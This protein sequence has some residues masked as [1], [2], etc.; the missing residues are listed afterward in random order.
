MVTQ[1]NHK[2]GIITSKGG[3]L[4]QIHQLKPIFSKH[5]RFWVTFKGKDEEYLLKNEKKYF[6]FYPES[7][8]LINA[9]LN[10]FL[11]WKILTKEKPNILISAGAGIAPPFFIVGKIMGMKLIFI[12]PYDFIHHPSL[13]GKIVS[14]FV[15]LF[16]VQH[17]EQLSFYKKAKYWGSL[18]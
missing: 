1:K 15:D 5:N 10:F 17:K 7:R 8:N 2:I 16:L 18:L 4:F 11:A 3:H 6:A 9:V 14:H 13:T 12:E